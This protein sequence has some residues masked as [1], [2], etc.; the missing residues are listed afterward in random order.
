MSARLIAAGKAAMP[1][2]EKGETEPRIPW[3]M[4]VRE[5]VALLGWGSMRYRCS[6]CGFEWDIWLA[7]G[8]EGPPELREAG[9]YLASPF[10][11]GWCPAWPQM[12]TCDGRMSHIDFH[13]DTAFPPLLIPD[14]APRFVIDEWHHTARLHVPEPALIAARRFHNE[15]A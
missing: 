15:R 13:A 2:A 9:L 5:A 7:L 1:D 11:I 12:Q 3:A 8:V 4:L 14:D 10:T 6:A